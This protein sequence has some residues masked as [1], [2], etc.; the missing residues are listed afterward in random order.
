MES[1]RVTI[2]SS[3][4]AQRERIVISSSMEHR[5][6]ESRDNLGQ[7][8]SYRSKLRSKFLSARYEGNPLLVISVNAV[9]MYRRKW[10]NRM[11][12]VAEGPLATHW[13]SV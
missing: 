1:E 3:G 12:S 7:T 4:E 13:P 8:C 5:L 2:E 10:E 11:N 9:S 6:A